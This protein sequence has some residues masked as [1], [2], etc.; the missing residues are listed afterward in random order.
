MI[1][2]YAHGDQSIHFSSIGITGSGADRFQIVSNTCG[3]TLQ[4]YTTCAIA[5]TF[6]STRRG[7]W[8]AT[9]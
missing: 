8:T 7:N 6:Q 1:Y 9:L 3:T 5:V 2:P 4:P